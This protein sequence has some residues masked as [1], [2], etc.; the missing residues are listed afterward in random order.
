MSRVALSGL[1]CTACGC[2]FVRRYTGELMPVRPRRSPIPPDNKRRLTK[3]AEEVALLLELGF[4]GHTNQ[5][6]AQLLGWQM[7]TITWYWYALNVAEAVHQAQKQRRQEK[8]EQRLANLQ[9]QVEMALAALCQQEKQ[10]SLAAVSRALGSQS[11]YLNSYDEI[12]HMCGCSGRT[13][14]P[15]QTTA[16]GGAARPTGRP[17]LPICLTRLSG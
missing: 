2:Q 13:Q 3:P 14:S 11:F 4:Q 17:S 6:I 7:R 5:E 15:M 12:A 8:R 1:L 10:I 16:D 9:T